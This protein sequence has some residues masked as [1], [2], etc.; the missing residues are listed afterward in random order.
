MT[1]KA[2]KWWKKKIGQLDSSILKTLCLGGHH[3]EIEKT[4]TEWEKYVQIIYLIR[5]QYIVQLFV[6]PWTIPHQAPPSMEFSR[7]ESWN[8][9]PFP[10]PRGSSQPRDWTRVSCIAG[11]RF[12]VW[13]TRESQYVKR[14]YIKNSYHRTQLKMGQG[15]K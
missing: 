12:T 11:R 14:E 5:V 13:A 3:Q 9:L 7:Q 2:H 1:Q 6:T 8:G 15:F 4:T 10:S